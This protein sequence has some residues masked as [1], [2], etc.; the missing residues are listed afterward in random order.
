MFEVFSILL[1]ARIPKS[2][3]WFALFVTHNPLIEEIGI[4]MTSDLVFGK[5]RG[6]FQDCH[7]R[8]F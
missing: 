8:Y 3:F 7:M 5:E 1:N 4:G 2:M 6:L